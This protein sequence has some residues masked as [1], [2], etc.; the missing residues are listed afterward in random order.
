MFELF[1]EEF[2]SYRD[3]VGWEAYGR[4][5]VDLQ[6]QRRSAA[7]S[8]A[9]Q[10][11]AYQTYCFHAGI[12]WSDR[13]HPLVERVV[14]QSPNGLPFGGAVEG[15][16]WLPEKALSGVP[17]YLWDL[18]ERRT[19]IVHGIPRVPQYVCISHTWGRWKLHAKSY[20]T[21]S[22]VP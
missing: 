10:R 18:I 11:L 20:S 21:I 3:V 22:E 9:C 2:L 1:A 7:R 8:A 16:P 15:C 14:C 12:S 17:Y 6:N 19:V 4:V 5:L 13:P